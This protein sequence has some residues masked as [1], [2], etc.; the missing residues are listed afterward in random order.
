MNAMG[1]KYLVFGMASFILFFVMGCA[2]LP[3]HYVSLHDRSVLT[4]GEILSTVGKDRVIFIGEGHESEVDHLLQFEIIKHL[5]STGKNVAIALEMFPAEMQPVLNQ[6]IMGTISES[7]FVEAYNRAW[8]VPYQYYA[9]IFEYARQARLPLVGINVNRTQI[10]DV[11]KHGIETLS[12]DFRKA[13][14]VASCAASPEYERMINLFEPRI[15]HVAGLP[16][17]C[18]AQLLR[19]T[20]MA[21]NIAGILER[22]RFTVVA[23]VGSAHALRMAV[24]RILTQY[25]DVSSQVL[26]S[27]TFAELLYPGLDAGIADYIWY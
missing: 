10:D 3:E 22:G 13:V 16:F 20:L 24:P 17:L 8:N 2:T 25:Y 7:E 15:A 26:M 23:L 11:A 18:D 12:G 9:K 6:W 27:K 5:H 14:R 21:Y 1:K 4:F 19:D